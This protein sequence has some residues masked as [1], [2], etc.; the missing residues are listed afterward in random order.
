MRSK[1]RRARGR[2]EEGDLR[3][4]SATKGFDEKNSQSINRNRKY[5]GS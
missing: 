5:L 3:Q 4:W 2:K 1:I